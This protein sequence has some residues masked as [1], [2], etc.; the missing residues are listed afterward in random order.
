MMGLAGNDLPGAAGSKNSRLK[1]QK[2]SPPGRQRKSPVRR[3][4]RKV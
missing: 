4:S 2:K 1:S 3:A